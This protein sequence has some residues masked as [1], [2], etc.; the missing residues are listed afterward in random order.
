[1]SLENITPTSEYMLSARPK[2]EPQSHSLW[3]SA[4][5]H[6]N[7]IALGL[8]AAGGLYASKGALSRL[9]APAGRDVLL[10]EDTP[11]IAKTVK[12]LIEEQGH[13][14]TWVT[15]VKQLKPFTAIGPDGGDLA[16]NLNRFRFAVV[17]GNLDGA[18]KGP[19]IVGTLARHRIASIAMSTDETINSAM[20]TNGAIADAPKPV[21]LTSLANGQLKIQDALASS[22]GLQRRLDFMHAH[23]F[24]PQMET[25]RQ[26]TDALLMKSF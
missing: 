9:I 6:K 20:R 10:I 11:Y 12:G 8:I 22:K 23:F 3:Q 7:A 24:D 13:N 21:F 4:Y 26:N 2:E 17:D 18:L 15:G 19:D 16:L 1:M 25:L 14:V 5:E